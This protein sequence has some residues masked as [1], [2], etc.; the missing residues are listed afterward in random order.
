MVELCAGS[1]VL[2]A[3][4]QRCGF[5]VFPIDHARNKFATKAAIFPLDLSSDFAPSLLEDMFTT[6][7]PVWCHMGL[8][9]GTCSRAREKP[10][11]RELRCQG[12][13]EP[14]PLRAAH[15]LFGLDSL[16]GHEQTRVQAANRVY[17]TA[18]HVLFCIFRLGLAVS[19]EN[20][21]RSW[22]WALLAALVKRRQNAAH[23]AWYFSLDD[24]TFDACCHG[25]SYPKTTRLK[26][27]QGV[28]LSLHARCDTSHSHAPWRIAKRDGQWH[29]DASS[30]AVYPA[31]LVK[32]MVQCVVDTLPASLLTLSWKL[33]RAHTVQQNALQHKSFPALIPEYASIE[34]LPE[35][36]DSPPCKLL[37]SPWFAGE[38][39]EGK[40]G[41]EAR[42]DS[43]TKRR[44]SF[45]KVGFF[46][47]P[48]QHVLRALTLEHPTSQF[49]VV[50]DILRRNLFDVFTLGT[51][52]GSKC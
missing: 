29:F 17:E 51:S 20:P 10:L 19:I 41:V 6:M 9:C 26:A 45:Y 22:L 18:E 11:S 23:T 4:A 5:Q 36:P 34:Y 30:E 31:L 37:D 33:L 47:D 15:A 13:P 24:I 48:Q 21:E 49:N 8:P 7:R 3:E 32:R 16:N 40:D 43:E 2:S 42:E 35:V 38:G 44:R 14:R 50:P 28:F 39:G 1:G 25:S 46:F 12:A 52:A 27:S